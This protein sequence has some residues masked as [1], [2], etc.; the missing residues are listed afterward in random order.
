MPLGRESK[1]LDAD[2]SIGSFTLPDGVFVLS[3]GFVS[4]T[5]V[6]GSF[7]PISEQSLAEKSMTVG[8]AT[9]ADN[10]IRNLANPRVTNR[11]IVLPKTEAAVRLG[12]S[13]G[14]SNRPLLDDGRIVSA[15]TPIRPLTPLLTMVLPDV[16][17]LAVLTSVVTSR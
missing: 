1:R 10:T 14:L 6:L 4:F 8:A 17:A 3:G 16:A 9:Q 2:W 15:S 12:L 7:I 13:I 5:G 11:Q